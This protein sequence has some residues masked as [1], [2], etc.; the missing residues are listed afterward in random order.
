ML[1]KPKVALTP[2]TESVLA[3]LEQA[4]VI[5]EVGGA[6]WY[7]I[8][9]QSLG[10]AQLLNDLSANATIAEVEPDWVMRPASAPV[11]DPDFPQEWWLQNTGQFNGTPGDDIN[12]LPA[13]TTTTGSRNIVVADLDSG[14]DLTHPDLEANLWSSPAFDLTVA[15]RSI[16]CPQGTHGFDAVGWTCN[17]QDTDTA[18]WSHGTA[19][20][21]M[22]G[23]VGNNGIGISGVEQVASIMALRGYPNHQID[24]TDDYESN[25]INAM[26]F[27][28]QAKEQLGVDVRAINMSWYFNEDSDAVRQEVARANEYGI[29]VVTGAGDNCFSDDQNSV[30]PGD[31]STSLDVINVAATGPQGGMARWNSTQCSNWGPSTVQVAAPGSD[32]YT[33]VQ[34]RGYGYFAGTS[35]SAP[36]VAG[37]VGLVASACPFPDDDAY[38]L[39]QAVL[40]GAVMNGSL[41]GAVSRGELN[42]AQAIQKCHSGSPASGTVTVTATGG[43]KPDTGNIDVY[44]DGAIVAD[45]YYAASQD[46]AA[47]LAS[48]LATDINLSDFV[49]ATADGTTVTITTLATGPEADWPYSIVLHSQDCGAPYKRDWR[50]P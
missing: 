36:L 43:Y 18:G 37:A 30:Y 26:E 50:L 33:T 24:N 35:M 42:V 47:G 10:A 46:T 1:F 29:V 9:S 19:V 11:N 21:G 28:V 38:T 13:W 16:S 27:A 5:E 48:A 8:R 32:G 41:T 40:D 2:G 23:A 6:G 12:V 34:G 31:Y 39:E 20:A 15:G 44:V 7:L 25:A 22:I 49:T 17:P 14:V 3:N 4:G 45:Q